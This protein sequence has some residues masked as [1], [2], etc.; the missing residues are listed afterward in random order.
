MT[1]RGI[2]LFAL[3]GLIWGIPYLF[4]KVAVAELTPE[5]LVL[6]RTALAA[7]VLLPI[8]ARR[9]A[10]VPVLR[11]WKLLV[12]FAV[13]E[14][15]LPWY[16]L[17]SAETKLPSSTTGLL[18]AA[19]PLVAVG[20]ALLFGRR[21]RISGVNA[22]GIII[23]MAGVGTIV[24][25]D[26]AGSDLVSVAQLVVV[27]VGYAV[28]PAILARWMSDLPGVGVIA[29]A[30]TISALISLPSVAIT[31]GWPAALPSAGTILSVVVLAVLC[32]AVAFVIMFELIAEIGPIR[33]TAITYVN[34]AVAVLAGALFLR[35]T[36]TWWTV[37]G[38]ALILAG[39][40]LVTRPEKEKDSQVAASEALASTAAA[41]RRAAP[42]AREADSPPHPRRRSAARR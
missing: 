5:F 33:S 8:A 35:E 42:S 24:G 25:F 34:P 12:A 19:I 37:A 40:A 27:V 18:L 32:S 17:N 13:V 3:L 22:A 11:R 29:L 16:F 23:G 2:I 4:I 20:V 38:F 7:A 26:L 36:I 28:G 30:L 39:S 1:R 6:A 14:I 41:A 9:G 10:V 15:V 21:D 31:G